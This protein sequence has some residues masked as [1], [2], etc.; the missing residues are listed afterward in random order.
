MADIGP[1]E[2]AARHAVTLEMNCNG[3]RLPTTPQQER[4]R[5]ARREDRAAPARLRAIED[6]LIASIMDASPEETIAE[7]REQGVDPAAA[8]TLMD[9]MAAEA[10]VATLRARVAALEAEIT[11]LRDAIETLRD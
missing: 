2:A 8:V 7:L 3:D 10:E 4:I 5:R 11:R 1:K 6:A 9:Q